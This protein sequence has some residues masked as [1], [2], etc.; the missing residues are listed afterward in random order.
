MPFVLFLSSLF[1]TFGWLGC[2]L[3]GSAE[4]V[5]LGIDLQQTGPRTNPRMYG[6]FLEEINHGIDG[7]LY[8]ELVRN[9]GF[10]DSRPPEGFEPAGKRFV[11]SA[12]FDS[13]FDEFGYST[14]QIN[15]WQVWPDSDSAGTASLQRE[16]GVSEASGYCVKLTANDPAS[17]GFGL[18][19]DGF[20][21]IGVH[22][23]ESYE[24]SSYAKGE[25]YGGVL[26]A[27]LLG[28]GGK[29]ISNELEFGAIGDDWQRR[30]GKLV[31]TS[32]TSKARL[33][34]TLK[35][36]G[37]VWL[38][39]VSLMPSKTWKNEPNGLRPDIAKMIADLKPGFVR[40]PGGCVVEGG[41]IET[42]YDWKLTVGPVE[43]RHERWGP[44]NHRRTHGMGLYEYLRFCS[45]L[46][47]EPLWV[48][49]CV[50]TCIFRGREHVPMSEM[51]WVRN[52]FLDLVE[53]A[54]GSTDSK[55][56]AERAK[57]GRTEPFDLQY[58]EI[59]NE[60][61]GRE[62]AE[63]YQYV[64]KALHD[65]YPELTYLGDLSW[66]SPQSMEG[67]E[68]D[69]IDRHYY[70]S[71]SWFISKYHEYDGRSR[72]MPPLYLG[73]VAVTTNQAGRLRGNLQAA[74][75]EG[76]FLLG[77]ERNAD[78]V[79]MV[80]YA[81]L[82]ANVQGRTGLTG[83]PP[84]WHAMIYFDG[85]RVFG[86]ASYYLW[87]MFGENR[88]DQIVQTTL[89]T[90]NAKPAVVTGQIGI[91]TWDSTAD[92]KDIQVELP[93]GEVWKPNELSNDQ[94]GGRWAYNAGSFEQQRR[95]RSMAYFGDTKWA[96]Y[97]LTLK[98]KKRSG[99][100]GFLIAFGRD[101][102][103]QFWW[104]IGGWGNS[105]HAIEHNQNMVGRA[106]RGRIENDRWYAIRI[107][108]NGNRIQCF[109]DDE[110]VHDARFEQ[111]QSFFA[112][113]G[114]DEA[115]NVIIVKAINIAEEPQVATLRLSGANSLGSQ[116]TATTLTSER[117]TDNNRLTAPHEVL[118]MERTLEIAGTDFPY[119]FPPRSLT[120]LR[121]PSTATE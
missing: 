52:G 25:D 114:V 11:N 71:P 61:Q 112:E 98:A 28:P 75:A 4:P 107:E 116:V 120:I 31:A 80:S 30:S 40:F 13:G 104:N 38:D 50:Q 101:G 55:W 74:L 37:T 49:F 32:T 72:D 20:F 17:K 46:Q 99:G 121:I 106:E 94:Q 76:V 48:G 36:S 93:S 22:E 118:P 88:P 6:I 86:T 82:L 102:G 91:G 63:R 53:Y 90:P 100:E 19:N 73:E 81:P 43:Q 58:V 10:E 105:Q 23:G 34:V 5:V 69:I 79:Q 77:C 56:G 24:F 113:T 42:A 1:A 45:N 78:A 15:F 64:H 84:P 3:A 8:S 54:N 95:G 111:P 33:V 97:T 92:F 60:N 57:A 59:G 26:I 21:G 68:F 109:L 89:T 51:E 119:E 67:S 62:Y 65:K 96:N 103:S 115:N 83:S 70:S 29:A 2:S 9:R 39:F 7:G 85:T 117:G 110:Q 87:K 14:D 44:W 41:S 35:S 18:A 16:G 47:A 27:K 66:T 12:D 108:V